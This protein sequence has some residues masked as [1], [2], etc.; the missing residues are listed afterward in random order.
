MSFESDIV[1]KYGAV[2]GGRIFFDTA[3]DGWTTVQ[4]AAPFC[5]VNQIN[6]SERWY[7]DNSRSELQSTHLQFFVWG[8]RR[9]EVSAAANAFRSAAAASNA[10]DFIV[11]PT[12]AVVNDFNEALKLRGTR[13]DFIF[14]HPAL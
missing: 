1:A 10:A 9:E 14:W 12:G 7:V 6:G 11:I 13:Q 5:I 8:A 3:P 4:M 2:F